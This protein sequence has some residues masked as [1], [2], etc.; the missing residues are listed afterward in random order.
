MGILIVAMLVL[1]FVAAGACYTQPL[2][3][4]GWIGWRPCWVSALVTP[5]LGIP[6]LLPELLA[7]DET[8]I[9]GSSHDW[10]WGFFVAFCV[11]GLVSAVVSGIGASIGNSQTAA[12]A[13]PRQRILNASKGSFLAVAL[14]Y[15]V[16]IGYALLS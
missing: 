1:P 8:S 7:P 15:T 4:R 5:I 10:A 14:L 16:V 12:Q 6:F 3:C 11:A 13:T 2:P 9:V